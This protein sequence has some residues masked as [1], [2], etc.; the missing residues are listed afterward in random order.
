MMK[1]INTY[2]DLIEEA[3][4]PCA[5][6]KILIPLI[7]RYLNIDFSLNKLAFEMS[8]RACEKLSLNFLNNDAKTLFH[9]HSLYQKALKK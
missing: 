3:K 4:L 9:F 5:S 1:K 6:L 2:H 7:E 8:L